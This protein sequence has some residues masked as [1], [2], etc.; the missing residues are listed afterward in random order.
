MK[1]AGSGQEGRIQHRCRQ[2]RVWKMEW[3]HQ[4][5][6]KHSG[7]RPYLVLGWVAALAVVGNDG[8]HGLPRQLL[9]AFNRQGWKGRLI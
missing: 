5:A 7:V 8:Q 4:L 3:R 9:N 1:I 2:S 6:E